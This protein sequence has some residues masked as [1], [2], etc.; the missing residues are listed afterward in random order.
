M[1]LD[2][3]YSASAGIPRFVAC[4]ELESKDR[5]E[6]PDPI[7]FYTDEDLCL[8]VDVKYI[9]A[10]G[11]G[12]VFE[13]IAISVSRAGTSLMTCL[14]QLPPNDSEPVNF[15]CNP[16]NPDVEGRMNGSVSTDRGTYVNASFVINPASVSDSGYYTVRVT[17]RDMS[18]VTNTMMSS[19]TVTMATTHTTITWVASA[20]AS[21]HP[22]KY[23][24][25]CGRVLRGSH[26][27]WGYFVWDD[28]GMK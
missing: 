27:I 17:A 19:E 1:C 11:S 24:G 28:Q 22:C 20:L 9:G 12:S 7:P 25:A 21:V 6:P 10:G 3:Y 23:G 15:N 16:V 18:Q 4:P 13:I 2:M 26:R 5:C 8:R 14:T